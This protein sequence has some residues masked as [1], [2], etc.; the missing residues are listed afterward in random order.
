MSQPTN[1]FT[2]TT[3]K[4]PTCMEMLQLILDGQC[5]EEQRG[6]FKSHMDNCM[7][8]FKSY[9]LDMSIKELLQTKCCGGDA[10]KELIEKIKSQIAETS[11]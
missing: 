11:Q 5:S 6:Y 8:C 9:Q 4:K 2:S 10:P 7:P 1:P 3:G